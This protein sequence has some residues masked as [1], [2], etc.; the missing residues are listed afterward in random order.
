VHN[1]LIRLKK[2]TPNI[3]NCTAAN[4]KVQVNRKPW[5]GSLIF[6][7]PQQGIVLPGEPES[8]GP[9]AGSQ[10]G[11]EKQRNWPSVY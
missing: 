4:K 5:K 3:V 8:T 10:T 7:S 1:W 11:A 9:D 6:F 2:S